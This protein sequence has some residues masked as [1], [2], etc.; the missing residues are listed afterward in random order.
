MPSAENHCTST[1]DQHALGQK[2]AL[3]Y[4]HWRASGPPQQVFN[5]LWL[6]VGLLWTRRAKENWCHSSL[7]NIPCL[8]RQFATHGIPDEVISNNGPP[9]QS[10]QFEAFARKWMF[11]HRT[12][13]PYHSQANGLVERAVKTAKS[14]LRTAIK[15][16]EHPWL[17]ILTYRNTPTQGMDTSP[18][19]RLRSRRTKNLVADGWEALG[20]SSYTVNR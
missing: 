1:T 18:V 7:Y 4:S 2:W 12:T 3:I 14:L 16:G 8:R 20:A 11:G 19:Q 17:A 5:N 13:S 15:A 6:L 10:Q 9:F